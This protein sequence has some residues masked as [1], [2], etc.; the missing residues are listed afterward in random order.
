M[1][2]LFREVFESR[3]FFIVVPLSPHLMCSWLSVIVKCL[4]NGTAKMPNDKG[5]A[6]QQLRLPEP[7]L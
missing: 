6:S 7:A 3:K 5:D 4:A 1:L 2:C